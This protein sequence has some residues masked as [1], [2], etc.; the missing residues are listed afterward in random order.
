MVRTGAAWAF[1]GRN[2]QSSPLI[3][4]E[5]HVDELRPGAI[6]LHIQI[7]GEKLW[8][9]RPNPDIRAWQNTTRGLAPRV[10]E[11][12]QKGR[13]DVLCRSGDMLFIDTGAWYHETGLPSSAFLSL[14]VAQ[15]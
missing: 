15:D 5:E 1:F 2:G 10:A 11:T 13:L 7:S 3:G 14:S 12:V 8:R 4:K 9:L 6:T